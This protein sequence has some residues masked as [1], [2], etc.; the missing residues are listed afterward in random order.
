MIISKRAKLSESILIKKI[1]Y[2]REISSHIDSSDNS[3]SLT[4]VVLRYIVTHVEKDMSIDYTSDGLSPEQAGM[5][6]ENKINNLCCCR[7]KYCH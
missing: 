7:V 5:K 1:L 2:R 4:G 6:K 3:R